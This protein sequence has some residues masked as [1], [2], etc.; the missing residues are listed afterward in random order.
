M[1][2][3]ISIVKSPPLMIIAYSTASERTKPHTLQQQIY[4]HIEQDEKTLVNSSF[5]YVFRNSFNIKLLWL[6]V[7][8]PKEVQNIQMKCEVMISIFMT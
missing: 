4:S 3:G 8:R 5:L 2:S 7:A 6:E 1:G